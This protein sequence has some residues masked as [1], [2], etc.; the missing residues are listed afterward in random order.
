MF[1]YPTVNFTSSDLMLK[2]LF[3]LYHYVPAF[4]HDIILRIQGSKIRL[5]NMYSKFWY[6]AKLLDYYVNSTWN[7][8][9]KQMKQLHATMSIK[10]HEDFFVVLTSDDYESHCFSAPEGL[11]KYFF[12][13]TDADLEIARKKFKMFKIL[14]FS[15][16]ALIYGSILYYA[17]LFIYLIYLQISF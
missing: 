11:R 3:F 13:D 12:K 17:Q 4:F 15:L 8:G 2:I 14:H 5:V 10:D 9:D 1:W 6:Q 7:F 16:L